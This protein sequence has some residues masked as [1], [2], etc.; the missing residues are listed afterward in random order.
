MIKKFIDVIKKG[1]ATFL[2]FLQSTRTIET[3]SLSPVADSL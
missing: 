2:I 3:K 1:S